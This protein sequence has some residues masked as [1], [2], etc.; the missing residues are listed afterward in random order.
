[1]TTKGHKVDQECWMSNATLRLERCCFHASV[2]RRFLVFVGDSTELETSFATVLARD[3]IRS[4]ALL[5]TFRVAA[6]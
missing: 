5:H 6:V 3:Q 4:V 2:A 1:M